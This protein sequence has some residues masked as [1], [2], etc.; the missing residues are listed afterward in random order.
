MFYN[1][2]DS[3]AKKQLMNAL[4]LDPDNDMAKKTIKNIKKSNDLKEEAS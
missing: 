4:E 2:N 1:G 3:L